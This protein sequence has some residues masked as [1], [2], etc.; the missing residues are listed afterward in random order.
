MFALILRELNQIFIACL[1]KGSQE[2][3]FFLLTLFRAFLVTVQ[4]IP[5]YALVSIRS[6]LGQL[7]MGAHQTKN[8]PLSDT[9]GHGTAFL[10]TVILSFDQAYYSGAYYPRS[11]WI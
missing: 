4:K 5:K 2:Q 7:T 3:Y 10:I 6:I 1:F 9:V 8:A 11:R